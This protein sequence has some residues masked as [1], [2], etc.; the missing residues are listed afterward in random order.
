MARSRRGTPIAGNCCAS[1]EKFDKRLANRRDRRIN[2]EIVGSTHDD[3]LQK[4]RK[5]IGDPWDMAKDGKHFF[6]PGDH[7]KLMRK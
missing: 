6:N 4:H 3:S 2:R 7:P 5:S 1:S